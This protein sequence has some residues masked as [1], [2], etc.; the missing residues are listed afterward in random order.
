MEKFSLERYKYNLP[1]K[2]IAR[3]P[4]SPRDSSRLLVYNRR[5][6]KINFDR[7]YNLAEYLPKDAVL[8]FNE[9]KVVQARLALKKSTGGKLRILYLQTLGE[10]IKVMSDRK[11]NIGERIFLN[12]KIY[13]DVA[14]QEENIFSL[15]PS[16][17]I[18]NTFD[19]FNKYGE[20]PIPPYIKKSPLSKKELR[21]KYQSVFAKYY[22]SVAAPTAS[23]HFTNRLLEKI[24]KAGIKTKFVTLHVNLGTFA[25]L[26]REN[27]K[28]NTLHQEYYEISKETA[29]FL[30]R[31]KGR[32]SPI[33]AVGTT[34]VRTLESAAE[35]GKLKNLKGKTNIF[36]REGYGFKFVD[37]MITNFHLPESSLLMLVSAF[38]G[39]EKVLEIYKTAIK[40]K[41]R[42]YS[43]GD[44]MLII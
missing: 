19:I 41:F 38:A 28:N 13:F 32:G 42:F 4:A 12:K 33:I 7:F 14:G 23:L 3:N 26:T 44:G 40:K 16:F 2:L 22:G 31:A 9:T 30:N 10:N 11:L 36:I 15:K 35:Q 39:R 43:F 25:P 20:A 6:G 24:K 8:V 21:E 34:V 29:N 5:T 27:F 37:A 1:E 18:E 17:P